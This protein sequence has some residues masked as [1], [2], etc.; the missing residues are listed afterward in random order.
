MRK[1]QKHSRYKSMSMRELKG[2]EIADKF[3][4]VRSGNLYLVP[5]QSGR[6]QY[7]V[8]AEAKR[9]SC[10]DFDFR[11]QPCKHIYAVELTVRR[12]RKTTVKT[13]PN[14]QTTT[15]TT[16][17]VTVKRKTYAQPSWPAY[18]ASQV[19]EKRIFLY[20]LHQ[21]CQGVGSPAQ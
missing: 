1:R 15:T 2:R 20:L 5:S 12:E 7:K 9:C 17:T 14:G 4:I 3:R 19:N 16:E 8:D 18:H 10:P 6:G 21:L 11:Q 13:A